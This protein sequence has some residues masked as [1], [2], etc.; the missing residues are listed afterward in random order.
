MGFIG[1]KKKK[2]AVNGTRPV[3]KMALVVHKG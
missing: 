2:L 1:K 3:I